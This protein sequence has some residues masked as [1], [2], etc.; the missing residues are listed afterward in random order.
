MANVQHSALTD[1]NLHEPKGI[2][3]ANANEL[4]VADGSNGLVI[5]NVSKPGNPTMKGY[6][7]YKQMH[8]FGKTEIHGHMI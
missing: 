4:Y 8:Q 1:P 3:S 2:A 5:L 7:H 6:Y